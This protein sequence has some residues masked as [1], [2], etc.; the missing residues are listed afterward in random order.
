MHLVPS[1][2]RCLGC[3]ERD[4]GNNVFILLS[5]LILLETNQEFQGLS[6]LPLKQQPVFQLINSQ[7]TKTLREPAACTHTSPGQHTPR[8][9]ARQERHLCSHAPC[10]AR[11]AASTNPPTEAP[12]CSYVSRNQPT[13]TSFSRD[14]GDPH[15]G[16]AVQAAWPLLIFLL[17]APGH[18]TLHMASSPRA[19]LPPPSLPLKGANEDA[20]QQGHRAALEAPPSVCSTSLG[21]PR[22]HQVMGT[23]SLKQTGNLL[24]IRGPGVRQQRLGR[25][26]ARQEEPSAPHRSHHPQP[27][28]RTAR[29]TAPPQTLP[30]WSC[31]RCLPK[32]PLI[33]TL[34]T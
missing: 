9:T 7:S 30:P 18:R 34:L 8:G 10:P 22:R 27:G 4:Y 14:D 15:K 29:H 17:L 19:T 1:T 28:T 32:Q 23:L 33:L 20:D 26:L 13:K 11:C 25:E 3:L 16:Q 6:A 5:V 24:A 2:H 31:T 21:H 12:V